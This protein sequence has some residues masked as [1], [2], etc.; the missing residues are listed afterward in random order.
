[1]R[2]A[3]LFTTTEDISA[4]NAKE[5]IEASPQTSF[6]LVDVRQPKEYLEQHIPGAILLPL[7]ELRDRINELRHDLP[8]IVYCRSGVR[9]KAGCQLL[10]DN[11]FTEVLNLQ[12]GILKWNGATAFG[13]EDFGL[14]FFLQGTYANGF[15]FAYHLE[16]GLQQFYLLL[17]KNASSEKVAE[18]LLKMAKIEDGH[19]AALIAQS[20]N[21]GMEINISTHNSEIVEGGLSLERLHSAFGDNLKDAKSVVQLAMMFESQSW[22]LYSRLA[23]K[24]QD[25]D[26]RNFYYKIAGEERKHLD[27]LT[28]ELDD[29]L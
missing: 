12:G 20:K 29:L 27:K 17:S 1:M 25:S 26:D 13:G 7:N 6:Q 2:W 4:A 21:A 5:F 14:D 28:A 8:T 9:S 10:Q 16:K 19:M 24:S 3:T 23:R 18:L 11:S 22:D 15:E